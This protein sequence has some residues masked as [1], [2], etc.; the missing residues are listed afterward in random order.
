MVNRPP[1]FVS[2]DDRAPEDYLRL[3]M[4]DLLQWS[5][6]LLRWDVCQSRLDAPRDVPFCHDL[7]C[8]A[9]L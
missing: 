9:H 1:V 4:H 3:R 6:D 5:V 8:V 2:D 7:Y